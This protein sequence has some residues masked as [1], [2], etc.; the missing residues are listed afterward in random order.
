MGQVWDWGTPQ[1]SLGWESPL[2][3]RI[4]SVG[5]DF[6]NFD[7]RH[8]EEPTGK[9]GKLPREESEMQAGKA[10][11][12]QDRDFFFLIKLF[13][14]LIFKFFITPLIF[15]FKG[16]PWWLRRS[17]SPLYICLLSQVLCDLFFPGRLELWLPCPCTSLFPAFLFQNQSRGNSNVI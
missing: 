8:K 10:V 7:E 6:Y 12:P 1:A 15:I 13:F 11:G 3:I 5:S 17:L 14:F 2:W 4:R 9:T 16:L